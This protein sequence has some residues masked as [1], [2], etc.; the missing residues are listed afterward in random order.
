[1][2]EFLPKNIRD[3][4]YE[5]RTRIIL[6]NGQG[7]RI[8]AESLKQLRREITGFPTRAGRTAHNVA[9]SPSDCGLFT[10][11]EGVSP[12]IDQINIRERCVRGEIGCFECKKILYRNFLDLTEICIDEEPDCFGI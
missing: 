11:H 2:I 8:V 9:G 3:L 4:F 10:Y 5:Y 7:G 12:R 6:T 1:M